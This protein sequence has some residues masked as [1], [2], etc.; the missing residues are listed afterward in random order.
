MSADRR[1]VEA[2]DGLGQLGVERGALGS[3]LGGARAV[4]GTAGE[5]APGLQ[6][7]E[8]LAALAEQRIRHSQGHAAIIAV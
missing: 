8:Q 5:Q 7:A 1:L 2:A 3:E 4:G 6:P